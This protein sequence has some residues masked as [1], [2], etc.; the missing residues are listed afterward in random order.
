MEPIVHLLLET[1]DTPS[2]TVQEAV[3]KCLPPLVA[4][5]KPQAA[6]T[7]ETLLDKV[8]HYIFKAI[9]MLYTY[10]LLKK[11]KGQNYH[12]ILHGIYY[13]HALLLLLCFC[14]S[15]FVMSVQLFHA[16]TYGERKGAAYGL[17][18]IVKGIGIPSLKQ[19]NVMQRLQ[20]A[21]Q[22]K[23]SYQHRE[24]ALLVFELLCTML[25]RL[26][27][28][29]VVKILPDLL[30]CY[31]DGN[32]YV[33]EV[34][35]F[36]TPD[37]LKLFLLCLCMFACLYLVFVIQHLYEQNVVV[38][39]LELKPLCDIWN[40]GIDIPQLYVIYITQEYSPNT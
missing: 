33:R 25:G 30:V 15:T 12:D 34:C 1:L 37:F 14:L 8:I 16:K 35:H 32:Q 9:K 21:I 24:G 27:E 2:Q 20:E 6:G 5:I 3:A 28:P 19:Y 13:Y 17:T 29:Y 36:T 39:M 7:I 38:F 40:F 31:G 23:K 11:I 26:F 18:A 22:N 10:F 4:C